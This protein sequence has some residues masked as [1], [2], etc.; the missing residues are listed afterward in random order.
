VARISSAT[1]S[2]GVYLALEGSGSAV[3][4]PGAQNTAERPVA[5][6]LVTHL[7][8]IPRDPFSSEG[9]TIT[10][11]VGGNPTEVRL[12]A[13][14][15]SGARTFAMLDDGLADDGLAGNEI[16]GVTLPPQAHNTAVTYRIEAI[17]AAGSRLFPLRTDR[18]P[19]TAI[20]SAT[21]GRARAS[22]STC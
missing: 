18:R 4:T 9:V 7:N 14:L 22:P 8:R 15:P 13:N 17:S 5:P 12:T 10:A 11:R 1:P 16:F 19:T 6:P 2:R 20:T 21:T 3:V